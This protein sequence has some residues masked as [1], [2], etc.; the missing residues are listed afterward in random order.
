MNLLMILSLASTAASIAG[1]ISGGKS[2]RERN[3]INAERSR[4]QMEWQNEQLGWQKDN[5][6]R[7]KESDVGSLLTQ[8][9][10]LGVSGPSI[11]AIK[12]YTVGE[13]NRAIDQA[14]TQIGWNNQMSGWNMEDMQ[15]ANK[16]SM[17]NEAVGIGSSLVTSGANLYSLNENAKY[18]KRYEDL[19][20]KGGLGV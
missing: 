13:Y 1:S 10:A 14:E 19:F 3:T 7:Q 9:G 18:K 11:D 2:E 17:F 4:Q 6:G 15:S 5:L 12:G 8:S 20:E 16:Q